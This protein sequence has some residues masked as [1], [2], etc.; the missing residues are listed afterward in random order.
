MARILVVDDDPDVLA[1]VEFRLRKEGHQVLAAASGGAA[2]EAVAEGDA[3]DLA[4]LDVSMPEMSGLTL[5]EKLRARDGMTGLPAI[6][7]SARILPEDIEAG[8]AMNAAYLTKPFV[9][10]ALLSAVNAALAGDQP[11]GW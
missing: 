4:V 8:R 2:L 1:L 3:P 6:F 9:A 5:L 11:Q 7:L 10:P